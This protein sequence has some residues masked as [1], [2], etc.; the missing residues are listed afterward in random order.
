M[1]SL[2]L[3]VLAVHWLRALCPT[4][5]GRGLFLNGEKSGLAREAAGV[6]GLEQEFVDQPREPAPA[7]G[8]FRQRP[9]TGA[10]QRVE[11]GFSF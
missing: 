3:D 11:L 1:G 5:G 8:L 10:C 9:F 2:Q 6:S 4:M 7:L